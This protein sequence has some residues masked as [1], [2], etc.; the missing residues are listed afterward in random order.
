MSR[1]YEEFLALVSMALG[2]L[3]MSID[4][5]EKAPFAILYSGACA[6]TNINLVLVAL[7]RNFSNG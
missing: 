6:A 1:K 5:V 3:T 2:E 7:S 4:S